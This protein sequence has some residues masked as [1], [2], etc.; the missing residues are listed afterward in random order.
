MS[1]DCLF[2]KQPKKA[3]L[4]LLGGEVFH[5]ERPPLQRFAAVTR[6]LLLMS[7]QVCLWAIIL[8]TGLVSEQENPDTGGG[9]VSQQPA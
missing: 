1:R 9:G 4:F 3:C 6:G 5:L 8:R 7:T 2:P